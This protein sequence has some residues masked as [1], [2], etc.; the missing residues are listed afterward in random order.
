MGWLFRRATYVG[1]AFGIAVA[2]LSLVGLVV[3]LNGADLVAGIVTVGS[4]IAVLAAL[5]AGYAATARR[6]SD[7]EALPVGS[8][9]L[10]GALAGLLT[11]AVITALAWLI[12]AIN[13]RGILINAS[14]Q[15][16][17][18]LHWGQPVLIGNAINLAGGALL[19]LLGAGLRVVPANV[20]RAVVTGITGTLFL[21]LMQ[22]FIGQILSGLSLQFIED[23]V[24][25]RE[26][27]TVI[28]AITVLVL[29]SAAGFVWASSRDDV[30]RR[31]A[32]LGPAQQRTAR[33]SGL[34]V[35]LAVLC[36]L[37]L[38]IGPFLS[39][40]L[41]LVGIYILLGLGLNIVVGF[42]GLL[43]LG[44]VAFYAVGAYATAVLT[45]PASPLFAPQLDFWIAVPLV[46]A[47]TAFIGLT[48]GAPVLR[49][50]GDYLAIVT[51]GFGEIAR[52]IFNSNWMTPY[53]GGS[54]GILQI[55]APEIFGQSL[56][57]PELLYYPI[58]AACIIAAIAAISLANSRVGR[59]W[60]A[61]RED[62]S[63]AEAT[64]VNTVK[65]KLLAFGLGATFGGL[66]GALYAVRI[67]TVF[68]QEL[69]IV[70]SI[71]ALALIILGGI[72][73]I[74]GVIVGAVVLV[75]L[76]EL[77]REFSEYRLLLYGIVLVA[78]MLLRP[79]GLLPNRSRRAELH[80]GE[81]DSEPDWD[82]KRWE[83][84]AGE[85][86]PEPTIT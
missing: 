86:T 46:L 64:G 81:G 47:I 6:K 9:L 40:T 17:D 18:I 35:A 10:A 23:F 79:E 30:K 53:L 3:A 54:Q 25:A 21:A 71:N 69:N 38:F 27:L 83:R 62:E 2:H 68:P 20:R 4:T 78:M 41:D 22:T 29:F 61:M 66:A 31:F 50:R 59:A 16:V 24:Y 57:A 48:I 70:V 11:G 8:A 75:G 63:V 72:G 32:A 36:T 43:D 73:S 26:G 55:P 56:R 33:F 85:D 60:T 65:Y 51:L 58:L 37:P 7:P 15:L 80:E 67:G 12:E 82:E 28:G 77:L 45:S 19:G 1:L 39:Q 5:S 49:L 42:A 76:P 14:P 44:Y 34:G 74:P 52:I 13:P 84:K